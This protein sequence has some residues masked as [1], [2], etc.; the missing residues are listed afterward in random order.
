MDHKIS[1]LICRIES[2][3]ASYYGLDV[4]LKASDCLLP[5]VQDTTGEPHQG[6]VL[7]LTE[8][9]EL[10]LGIEF[11]SSVADSLQRWFTPG[12][13]IGG[14]AI[15]AL[16][17][18]IEEVSHF[19]LLAQR[20]SRDLP[21]TQLE[22]EW[23]AEVDKLV[24][25][26]ELVEERGARITTMGLCHALSSSFTLREGM[27]A[28]D[29]LRYLEATRYFTRLVSSANLSSHDVRDPQV[30]TWLRRLYRMSWN[31]KTTAIAA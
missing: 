4:I 9:E 27:S 28:E 11:S 24:V 3:L 22:L 25:L 26:P 31:N 1:P 14:N 23:Q 21:V 18:V 20:A 13:V 12:Q 30:R 2:I 7:V 17:V 10:M 5:V 8:G 15:A 29:S 6:R 16:L 19:Q